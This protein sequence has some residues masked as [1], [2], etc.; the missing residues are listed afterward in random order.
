MRK[1]T[2]LFVNDDVVEIQD[3]HPK[4]HQT[5]YSK[6]AKKTL[7]DTIEIL[8]TGI[9]AFMLTPNTVDTLKGLIYHN[10]LIDKNCFDIDGVVI[11]K[12][13]LI[14]KIK[15]N[16]LSIESIDLIESLI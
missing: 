6:V 16:D 12:R 10:T 2:V 4:F 9:P 5:F 1:I 14:D 7:S 3:Y 11:H 15:D 13:D 8:A